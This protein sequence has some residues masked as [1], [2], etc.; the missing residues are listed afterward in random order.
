MEKPVATLD[1]GTTCSAWNYCGE[2][3]AAG[4]V[5]GFL[6]ILDSR[7][8]SSSSFG[9]SSKFK[10]HEAGIA[11]V[12]WIPP[13]YGDAVACISEDGILSIWEE[14]VEGTQPLQW[15]HCKSFKTT[16]KVLD[17]QFGVNQT[18]LKMVAASSDGFVKVFELL[19]PL[20]LKNW[21]LQVMSFCTLYLASST[22]SQSWKVTIKAKEIDLLMEKIGN[23]N[24]NVCVTGGAGYIG[25]S[26]VKRLLEKGYTVHTTLRNLEDKSKAGLLKSL[27]G[28]ETNLVLFEADIYNPYQF[29]KA[30]QG[31]EFV[32]HVATP[33]Q[34]DTQSL[35]F[36]DTAEAA[37]A[38][39][40]RI[41]DSCIRSETVK[42][43][44][45]TASV[46][47][48]SPL[49]EEGFMCKSCVD[50]SCW[51][52]ADISFIQCI[53][54]WRAYIISKILA[55]KE[56][57]SYNDYPDGKLEVVTLVCGVVGGET[58]LPYVPSSVEAIISQLSGN[59]A[60]LKALGCLLE[61]LGSIPLVHIDDVC[62]AHIFCMKK[63]SMKGRFLCVAANQTIREIVM[64]FR[65][66]YPQYQIAEKLM[67]DVDQRSGVGWDCSKLIKMGFQYKFD[68]KQILDDSVKC[69]RRLGALFQK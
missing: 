2:R 63:P 20:E 45:Y 22:N 55:E 38:G 59:L 12:A 31:C 61:L 60:A 27:P 44:I 18:S 47:A 36:K 42:R 32:F 33:L 14:I 68:T 69:G 9:C 3:L 51:T 10:V 56:A 34:H 7:D 54:F 23:R 49:T 41:A 26:L 24:K 65:E 1:R 29:E 25:S 30:I 64:Y 11:K 6:S 8:P 67:G 48:A 5:D 15:K 39:V 4:S 40:R 50:E 58:N 37:V 46:S 19:D 66:N 52:P 13:E 53:E 17:V 16:S 62:D 43:L 35:Q 28:A 21:Q 57:L